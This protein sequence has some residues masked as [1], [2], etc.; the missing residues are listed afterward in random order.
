VTDLNDQPHAE[1]N[2]GGVENSADKR[3]ALRL[4]KYIDVTV[5]DALVSL[6]FRGAIADISPTG[7][8]MIVDQYLPQGS[9]YWFTMKRNP[10]LR[11]RG[12]VRWIRPF[13]SDTF[14]VGVRHVDVTKEDQSR[15]ENFLDLESK[16]LTTHG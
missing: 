4:R 9:T 5:E 6:L 16:R 8:R 13:D 15:L 1:D 2:L 11:L 12:E 3:Y 7:M 10:F 14:Q